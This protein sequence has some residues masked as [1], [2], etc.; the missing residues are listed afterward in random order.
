[1]AIS[2]LY[3]PIL[4]HQLDTVNYGI[5]LT[6]TSIVSWCSFLDIGLGHG[7]RNL[8]AEAI[9]KNEKNIMKNLVGT[10]Y[11]ILTGIILILIPI[12]LISFPLFDW[13]KILN[14]PS[15]MSK[16]LLYLAIIVIICFF[17]Q[18]VLNLINSILF[19]IQKP[20]QSSFI[21]FISQLVAF[22]IVYILS[23]QNKSYSLVTYGSIISLIPI[24][25]T[26]IYTIYLFK[27]KLNFLSFSY[28][29][30][31]FSLAPQLFNLGIKFFFI[32]LT[33]IILFQ[34]NNLILTHVTGPEK[35][36]DFN[37]SYKY[38]G[39]ISMIFTIIVTPIWSA[40]TEAFHK[41][42]YQWIKNTIKTLRKIFLLISLVGIILALSSKFVYNIWLGNAVQVD[43]GV[44]FLILVYFIANMWCG[45]HCNILN[46]IGKVKL[47][48]I[49]TATEALIH[50]PLAILLGKIF[51]IYGVLTSM[52]LMTFINTI[53]EP[54]QINKILN[55]KAKGIWNS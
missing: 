38:I 34:T 33:A 41:Q 18:F 15:S 14:A 30:I 32:Q 50:L 7:L 42:D 36:T 17:I 23:L 53:W 20:A 3:V 6:L 2:F 5:W 31:N 55:K 12:I 46:G 13:A 27:T 26:L 48:F 4:I 9:A 29:N 37:I 54:I 44:Q 16:E 21:T 19:A 35:V 39:I 43:Y 22:I 10:S 1:M 25:I 52:F 24:F 11:A 47:Q 40:T 28:K 49:I 8:L 45:I 51:G